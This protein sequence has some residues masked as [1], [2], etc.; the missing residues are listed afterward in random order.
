MPPDQSD[1][2]SGTLPIEQTKLMIARNG[3]STTFSSDDQNPWPVRNNDCQNSTGTAASAKPAITKPS[4]S[5]LRSMVRSLTVYAAASD[6]PASERV[7]RRHD[8]LVCVAS[9]AAPWSC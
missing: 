5:S 9:S 4:T 1:A 7:R 6:Q 2:A 8:P 3:P